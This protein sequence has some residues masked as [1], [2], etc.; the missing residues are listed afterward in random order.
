MAGAI[1]LILADHK[2]ICDL[3]DILDGHYGQ[4]QER[5]L[6]LVSRVAAGAPR[7]GKRDGAAASG[8]PRV[9]DRYHKNR[10]AI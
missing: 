3:R 9:R 7:P 5:G 6:L 4:G 2:H 10:Y 1:G 8:F